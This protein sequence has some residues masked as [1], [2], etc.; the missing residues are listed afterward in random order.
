MVLVPPQ[1][2]HLHLQWHHQLLVFLRLRYQ[3]H[4]HQQEMKKMLLLVGG[5]AKAV[6]HWVG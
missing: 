2:C 1:Y 6:L 3:P 5:E 4:Q